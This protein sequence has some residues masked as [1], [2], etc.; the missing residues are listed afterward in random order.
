MGEG[1]NVAVLAYHGAQGHFRALGV[2]G[3]KLIPGYFKRLERTKDIVIILVVI[4][5]H[6]VIQELPIYSV[7]HLKKNF[8]NVWM[9]SWIRLGA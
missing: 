5:L 7:L 4:H 8:L 6:I 2:R 9:Q 1:R 3:Y